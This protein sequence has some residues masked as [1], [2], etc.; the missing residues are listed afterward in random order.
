MKKFK[1]YLK[2]NSEEWLGTSDP[3]SNPKEAELDRQASLLH[4][5]EPLT[6]D[7]GE[8]KHILE[9]LPSC[10]RGIRSSRWLLVFSFLLELYNR[11]KPS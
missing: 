10:F 7:S 4:K 11:H 2:E 3:H 1:A 9:L 8:H 6:P 5:N